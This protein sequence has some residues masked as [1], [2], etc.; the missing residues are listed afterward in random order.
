[1][2]PRTTGLAPPKTELDPRTTELAPPM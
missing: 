2:A 1:M